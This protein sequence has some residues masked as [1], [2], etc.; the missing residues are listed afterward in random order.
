MKTAY[1]LSQVEIDAVRSPEV[2]AAIDREE[3]DVETLVVEL[4]KASNVEGAGGSLPSGGT[5]GQLLVKQS[6]TNGDA[7]WEPLVLTGGSA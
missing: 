4:T 5:R 1:Y 7:L 6:N 2:R 3:V